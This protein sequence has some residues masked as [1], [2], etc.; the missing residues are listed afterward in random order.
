MNSLEK[1][2]EKVLEDFRKTSRYGC[3][4]T[5]EKVGDVIAFIRNAK[6]SVKKVGIS[7]K[8]IS[9][10]CHRGVWGYPK[11]FVESGPIKVQASNQFSMAP[12]ATS[13]DFVEVE[14]SPLKLQR[15]K[16]DLDAPAIPEMLCGKPFEL[17]HSQWNSE[18][19]GIWLAKN[20]HEIYD[21]D[22]Q[23]R[24]A[25]AKQEEA[26]PAEADK[27]L[28]KFSGKQRELFQIKLAKE[29][30]RHRNA[31]VGMDPDYIY[32]L[33]LIALHRPNA[34]NSLV[35][36]CSRNRADATFIDQ[37]DIVAAMNVAKVNEVMKA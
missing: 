36:F 4:P 6:V 8:G 13:Y 24:D 7:K 10:L 22:C 11:V 37:T 19:L 18:P 16:V 29:F 21:L 5:L 35:N 26:F 17:A 33:F 3:V 28:D 31:L 25:W 14:G 32:E 15:F 34:L 30:A 12:F 1:V 9:G 23:I 20:C 27:Y 2:L